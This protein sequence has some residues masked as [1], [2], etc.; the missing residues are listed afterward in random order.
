M[1]QLSSNQF[2]EVDISASP[3]VMPALAIE[4]NV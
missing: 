1:A 4:E 2:V 3:I